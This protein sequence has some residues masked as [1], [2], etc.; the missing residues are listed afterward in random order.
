MGV[1]VVRKRAWITGAGKGIGR[2]LALALARDGWIVA[3]SARSKSDLESLSREAEIALGKI[4]AF[5]LDITNPIEI[6]DTVAA[7]EAEVGRIDLAVLNAGTH[8]PIQAWTF[9]ASAFRTLVETNLMGTVEC[10]NALLPRFIE[11]GDGRIGVVASVAGY[12]G[13]PTAAGYGATKAALINMC[14]ALRPELESTGVTLQLFSPGFVDTPLARKNTFPMPFIVS[15]EDAAQ[16]ILKG[17]GKRRFE[18]AFPRRMAFVMKTLRILP[19]WLFFAI[20]RRMVGE[21]S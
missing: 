13:L 15:A 14:E 18:I 3:A 10:L 16:A 19:D 2:A 11:R 9:D 7:I 12:R 21:R 6:T 5:P 20:T 1:E 8:I 4:V 17:L